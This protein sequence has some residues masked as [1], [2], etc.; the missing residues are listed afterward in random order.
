MNNEDAIKK[1]MQDA[2]VF[3]EGSV[4]ILTKESYNILTDTIRNACTCCL[5]PELKDAAMK[6]INDLENRKE[7]QDV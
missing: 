5:D 6:I 4:V 2:F 1:A 7:S 3:G